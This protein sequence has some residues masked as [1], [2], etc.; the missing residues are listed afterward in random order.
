[1]GDEP[2]V[3][4][5]SWRHREPLTGADL[6]DFL[7]LHRVSRHRKSRVARLGDRYFDSGFRTLPF[8]T[9]GF[10]TLIEIGHLALGAPDPD[11]CD[12]QRVTITPEG[13]ARYEQL[14]AKEGVP[15]YP[16]STDAG[17]R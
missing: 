12:M 2:P 9:D 5:E 16:G 1:M 6:T 11:S 15:P 13:R 3:V 4:S 14:C 7:I 17:A 10:A 8:L